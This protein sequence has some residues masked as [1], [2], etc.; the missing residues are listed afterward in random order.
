MIWEVEIV[1]NGIYVVKDMY[2]SKPILYR[3]NSIYR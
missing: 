2:K 1:Y 3:D